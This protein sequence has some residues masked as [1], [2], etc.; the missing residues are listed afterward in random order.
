MVYYNNYINNKSLE[1]KKKV[2]DNN[3]SY[4]IINAY[5]QIILIILAIFLNDGKDT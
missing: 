3:I 2:I 4:I 1:K 5:P